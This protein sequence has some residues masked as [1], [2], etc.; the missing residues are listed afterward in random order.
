[1]SC[2]PGFCFWPQPSSGPWRHFEDWISGQKLNFSICL[3]VSV[4][5]KEDISVHLQLILQ[6]EL[7]ERCFLWFCAM[8]KCHLSCLLRTWPQAEVHTPHPKAVPTGPEGWKHI[9]DNYSTIVCKGAIRC[10]FLWALISP[11]SMK[12]LLKVHGNLSR[13]LFGMRKFWSHSVF[14]N[15]H[16]PRTCWRPLKSM[17][18][19]ILL[20]LVFFNQNKLIS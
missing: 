1:M 14:H 11:A 20:L 7:S 2:V 10:H 13:N 4:F 19:K 6:R 12:V 17:G 15:I 9:G 18:P 8:L 3:S 16:L 5:F